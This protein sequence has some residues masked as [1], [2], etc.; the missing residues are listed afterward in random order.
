VQT[1]P[2]CGEEQGSNARFCS[3]C[4]TALQPPG[5][6]HQER[7]VVTVLFSDL[8]GS[9]AL[10]EQ[11]D[12]ED[13]RRVQA[14][15]FELLNAEVVRFGGTTEKFVGDAVLAVF[16]I[17]SAHED[18]PERAVRAALASHERF[19]GFAERIESRFAIDV[20]LRTGINTG[21]VVAS[22][23][24]AARGE[25]MVSGDAVNV[26]ARLQQ[27]AQ[28]GEVLVGARTQAATSRAIVYGPKRELDAKGKSA[29][30]S[31]WEAR[32]VAAEPAVR[33]S[34]LS[35][36]LIGREDELTLLEMVAARGRRE[37]VPQLVTLFGPA[38]VGKSRLVGELLARVSATRVL[39][40]PC[41]PYG[42]GITYWPLAEA[43]KGDA[44]ILDTDPAEVAHEKLRASIHAVVEQGA[45]EVFDAIAWTIGLAEDDSPLSS[46]DTPAVGSALADGWQRYIGA[47]GRRGLT[48]LVIEDIHWASAALLDL[49][50]HLV[51]RIS[52]ACV[53]LICTARPE[54]LAENPSWGAGKQN[55]TALSLSPLT[56]EE[57]ERLASNLLGAASVPED[58]RR[59]LLSSAEGN[60]FFLEEMLQML[61]DEGAL[62]QENGRWA[63]TRR[64]A[65]LRIPDSVHGVI[66][67][68]LDLLDLDAREALRRCA[69]VG[70]V[71]WPSAVGV[72]EE[73]VAGLTG[74]GLV[75]LQPV[76]VMGGLREF[77]FKHALTRDVAYA[78]LPRP[79][80]RALH[81][82]VAEWIQSVAP[83]REVETAELAGYHY[84]EA[85]AYGEDD[86]EVARRAYSVLIAAGEAAKRRAAL[87]AANDHFTYAVG[88]ASD[89]AERARALLGLIEG[90]STAARWSEALQ[91]LDEAERLPDIDARTRSEI[92]GWRSRV[93]WL[94]GRWAEALESAEEAVAALSGL[95]E[96]VQLARAV[97]RR[98][99]IEM[100]RNRPTALERAR[101][102]VE[103]A[104]RVGDEYSI[105]NS[106]INLM[107]VEASQ[108]GKGPDPDEVRSIS[109]RAAAIGAHEEATRVLVNFTWSATGYLP[110][111]QIESV[112]RTA[113]KKVFVPES[114]ADYLDLSIGWMLQLPAGR[115][116]ELDDPLERLGRK[117]PGGATSLLILRPLS[118]SLAWR[119]GELGTAETWLAGLHDVSVESGEAQ[120]IVPS[121]TA[122]VPWLHLTGR[123]DEL[124]RVTTGV[125]E[126]VG[127]EWPVVLSVDPVL[128]AVAAS[129]EFDLL[130]QTLDSLRGARGGGVARLALSIG[131]GDALLDIAAGRF[132]AAAQRLTEAVARNEELGFLYD[133]A[134][135]KLDLAEALDRGGAA[136]DAARAGAEARQFLADLR[137]VHAF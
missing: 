124:R 103:I 32:A 54:F 123:R 31:A 36:P 56:P 116:D 75:S 63:A 58:V 86:P 68:R 84:R 119:R 90:E 18:D 41:L 3:S 30:V 73:L 2:T 47:L 64:L 105:I 65:E 7:R 61:I 125:I 112:V 92:L 128:R 137:C 43:A 1:C 79:E 117:P 121:A 109:Q 39:K 91:R 23:E 127:R 72:E 5:E 132:E 48:M 100:L 10:A 71:F 89:D 38:G 87:A 14:E 94:T 107:T 6:E 69:V 115:W 42:E 113:M 51:D 81:R 88:L 96:S 28:L 34:E 129:G 102:A 98:S 85:I 44:G 95:P 104:E 33:G 74:T 35:A 16:G 114:I 122:V 19:A 83:D 55:V 52:D 12:P 50:E 76:S 110:I 62:E 40:G 53:V 9:T 49:V 135:L 78:S 20:G 37:R 13:V 80:R 130:E 11:L 15:L 101:E 8:A 99:Q 108:H 29:P 46:M 17:P 4:G 24:T 82:R 70:R 120:R 26:A 106:W 77:T 134:C 25:L 126:A 21:N 27:N 118:G 93:S 136:N 66:A 133:A 131:V 67:A 57:S 59:P 97:A 60:P 45:Q 22:R 111:S